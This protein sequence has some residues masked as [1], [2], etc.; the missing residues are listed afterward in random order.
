[1]FLHMFSRGRPTKVPLPLPATMVAAGSHHS[2]FLL[3]SGQV[4][5]CGDHQVSSES[6]LQTYRW[7]MAHGGEFRES[8]TALSLVAHGSTLHLRTNTGKRPFPLLRYIGH[9][10]QSTLGNMVS[11]M[12]ATFSFSGCFYWYPF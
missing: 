2:A 9:I 10:D 4:F 6:Q 7:Y 1:M 8:A 5:T 3:T 12:L 11:I